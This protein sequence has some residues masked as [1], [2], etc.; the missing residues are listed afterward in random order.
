MEHTSHC[1]PKKP[2]SVSNTQ[3]VGQ[4]PH[5]V[6]V[7]PTTKG[8]LSPEMRRLSCSQDV[9]FLPYMMGSAIDEHYFS[10]LYNIHSQASYHTHS[11]LEGYY[12][13][14]YIRKRNERERQR[15]KCV[16]EGYARLQSHL[17]QEYLEKRLSKV[18]TLKAAIKYINLL[19][20]ALGSEMSRVPLQEENHVRS[21]NNDEEQ[22]FCHLL[23]RSFQQ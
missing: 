15:V 10:S 6:C 13:P 12:G 22:G 11:H 5:S 8:L 20:E 17:P 21:F 23:R 1:L 3:C 2:H 9:A 18:Q 7:D 16:N 19:Q 4:F 14:S